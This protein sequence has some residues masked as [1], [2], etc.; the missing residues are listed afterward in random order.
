[1]KKSIKINAEINILKICK[2][3]ISRLDGLYGGNFN[4]IANIYNEWQGERQKTEISN[5]R[6]GKETAD[7]Q[8][9]RRL[10]Y[11]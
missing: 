8:M 1:M 6:S 3:E 10:Y 2:T 5:T 9:M 11:K 7:V 4:E